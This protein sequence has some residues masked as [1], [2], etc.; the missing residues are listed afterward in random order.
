VLIIAVYVIVVNIVLKAYFT[1][2]QKQIGAYVGLIITNCIVLGRTE[3][4]ALQNPP[5]PSMVDGMSN[6]LG[7]AAVLGVIGLFRELLGTGQVLGH[8]VLSTSWYTPNQIM[9]LAPGAFF[10]LGFLIAGY[11]VLR[12]PHE[13][14]EAKP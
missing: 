8:T 4:F 1:E 12:K 2:I 10:A 9:V 6:G 5:L 7:Y 14:E 3:A 11:N 13:D